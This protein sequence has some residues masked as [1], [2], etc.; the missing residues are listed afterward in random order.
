VSCKEEALKNLS[1]EEL[2]ANGSDH[3]KT[4]GIEPIDLYRDAGM[5]RHFALCSIMK[6]A[7][8]NRN[9]ENPI[10]HKDMDKI[11]DYAQKLKAM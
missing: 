7:F 2:K 4:G 3:Y 10:S 11:I 6:Y 1:W 5:L 9:A 8:R